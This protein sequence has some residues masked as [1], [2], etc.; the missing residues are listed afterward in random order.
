[1]RG[2]R[3]TWILVALLAVASLARIQVASVATTTAPATGYWFVA[4]DGGIFSFGDAAFFGSQGGSKLNRPIV[5]MAAT[6]TG[7]GYWFVAADGGIF[8]FG[9][10]AFFGSAGGSHLN[11]PIVGMAPTSAAPPPVPSTV[12]PSAACSQAVS[13]G[14]EVGP[15]HQPGTYYTDTTG[16]SIH[17]V[18]AGEE[19]GAWTTDRTK[20]AFHVATPGGMADLC[21]LDVASGNA[22][23]L[24]TNWD[25]GALNDHERRVRRFRTV[26]TDGPRREP[27]R[28]RPDMAP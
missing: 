20:L 12:R 9:D 19:P 27:T 25:T 26:P 14:V 16:L 8:S 5:G 22:V 23:R 4:A 6:P 10:A 15:L 21:V 17:H 13:S 18:A 1:M 24:A 2:S 3:G 11:A 28:Q 7:H